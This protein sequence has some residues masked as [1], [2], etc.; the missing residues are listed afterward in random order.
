MTANYKPTELAAKLIGLAQLLGIEQAKAASYVMYAAKVEALKRLRSGGLGRALWKKNQK[1]LS[2]QIYVSKLVGSGSTLRGSIEAYG[3]AAKI[4]QGEKTKQHII[5]PVKA[6]R[7]AFAGTN[8]FTGKSIAA[9]I[10][11]H[12]GSVVPARPFMGA[13]RA[14]IDR[15]LPLALE[16]AHARVIAKEIG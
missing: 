2:H 3:S 13:V 7:L 15:D 6:K 12:P 10:V 5:R 14:M 16:A 1:S 11:R 4:D 8:A 9:L